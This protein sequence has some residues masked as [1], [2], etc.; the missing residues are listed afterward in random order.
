MHV[1]LT[2]AASGIGAA[3][4]MKLKADGHAVTA[5]DIA[6]PHVAVDRFI[7]V[8]MADPAAID[9]AAAAVE[10]P[11]DALINNAG[12]PPRPGNG[13]AVLGVNFL[14]LRR[15]LDAM[16][17]KLARGASIVNTA[18]RAGA[19]WR[20]NLDQV[21]ALMALAGPDELPG[22]IDTHTIDH[23]RAY[24]LS[25]EALI[26]LTV[27]RTSDTLAQG[28][29]MNSVSPAAVS[30]TILDDFKAA[31]GE[32]VARNLALVGRPGTAGEVADV[33][34]W[35]AS[36][37]SAWVKGQDIVIDGGMSAIATGEALGLPG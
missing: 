36:P 32:K 10:G 24:N 13:A 30:T 22:F 31:F 5:F 9:A 7:A 37:A 12:L 26:A 14:G 18:S 34:C 8:D 19:A 20:E 33:I 23:V 28:L 17:P 6:A 35:L 16:V 25:K 1:A 27:A 3:V 29:R 4:A 2:G 11:F 21:K 15:F